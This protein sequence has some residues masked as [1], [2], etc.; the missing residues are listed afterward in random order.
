MNAGEGR[1]GAVVVGARAGGARVP[2]RASRAL[3]AR[4]S[5]DGP[6]IINEGCLAVGLNERGRCKRQYSSRRRGTCHLSGSRSL[7]PFLVYVR[8]AQS[9]DP[10]ATKRA[11]YVCCVWAVGSARGEKKSPRRAALYPPIDIYAAPQGTATG[12]GD[13]RD[14]LLGYHPPSSL[15]LSHYGF[16]ALANS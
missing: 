5:S 14:G 9:S 3:Q 11:V 1:G 7:T 15:R 12:I 4:A 6:T 16:T 13:S 8:A 2:W 10:L